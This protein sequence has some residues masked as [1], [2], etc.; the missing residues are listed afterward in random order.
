MRFSPIF[1]LR[2]IFTH[3]FLLSFIASFF[4][5]SLYKTIVQIEFYVLAP[6][7]ILLNYNYRSIS[8]GAMV[9]FLIFTG[10][11]IMAG[12]PG[13]AFGFAASATFGLF[14]SQD[15]V[16]DLEGNNKIDQR[17]FLFTTLCF[18]VASVH[19]I[20]SN[21]KNVF[22]FEQL[23]EYFGT[24]SINY[25]SITVASFCS[26]FAA[27]ATKRKYYG[28]FFTQKQMKWCRIFAGI[29]AVTIL[30]LSIIFSTRSA[31]FGF[32][33][34]LL[35]ALQPKKPYLYFAMMALGL[36]IV[37][38]VF[39]VFSEFVISV[40]AP[41]RDSLAELYETE[42][43]GQERSESAMQIYAIAIPYFSFCT[44]CSDY[45][46]FSGLSNLIALSFPFSIFFV[47]QI[48]RFIV[49]YIKNFLIAKKVNR[50]FFL[51]IGLSFLN[52]LLL[53]VFQADFLS[54]LSLFYV[55]GSG[56]ASAG[57]IIGDGDRF[58]TQTA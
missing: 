29:L 26:I 39:P 43:K 22:E 53:S 11:T 17:L 19:L 37:Y 32:L 45:L 5:P 30:G 10:L 38:F 28:P 2:K 16:S 41:G 51:I 48:I 35:F 47:V 56:L 49:Q 21:I 20:Y 13:S 7:V 14:M 50:L 27:W 34:P 33:P 12:V 1:V 58:N 46:S 54:M 31:I 44:T 15:R 57:K 23:G 42:L 6:I 36:V 9:I 4:F 24:A 55:V 8:Q 3:I 52:S 40:M 25:A 18:I